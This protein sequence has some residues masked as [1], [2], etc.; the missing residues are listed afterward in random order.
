MAFKRGNFQ[1]M[2][3]PVTLLGHL[4]AMA[5]AALILV[6][7]LHFREGVAFKSDNKLKILN[8]ILFQFLLIEGIVLK[9]FYIERERLYFH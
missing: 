1:I 4:V 9:N 7:I 5:V 2:A 6:W 8:V 3:R